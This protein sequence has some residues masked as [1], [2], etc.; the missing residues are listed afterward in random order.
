MNDRAVYTTGPYRAQL[1]VENERLQ[2]ALRARLQEEEALRRV[3][4][5]VARAHEPGAVLT[6]VTEEVGR[7]LQALT[8]VT[9]RYDPDGWGTIVAI[10]S[11]APNQPAFTVGYRMELVPQL[12]L[13]RVYAT[14]APARVDS[15][16]GMPGS[17]PAEVRA[18]GIR[19]TVAAPVL[20][21]GKL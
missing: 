6:R 7:H 10:W 2:L 15:Y 17:F 19:A 4:T 5:L 9:V 21:D 20:V 13:G 18:S 16:E 12:A 8:T 11:A 14:G 3:A 1:V